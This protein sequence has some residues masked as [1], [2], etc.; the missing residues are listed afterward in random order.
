MNPIEGV[1]AIGAAQSDARPAGAMKPWT[2]A[3]RPAAGEP[4]AP[5]RPVAAGTSEGQVR[6]GTIGSDGRFEKLILAVQALHFGFAEDAPTAR[7]DEMRAAAEELFQIDGVPAP[8]E[9]AAG[10]AIGIDAPLP[11]ATPGAT[12]G[13]PP[14]GALPAATAPPKRAASLGWPAPAETARQPSAAPVPTAAAPAA[15][16]S[17]G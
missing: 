12:P 3:R 13:T 5:E 2:L 1:S 7:T 16:D 11:E 8:V 14:P 17:A 9:P 10:P 4:A 15:G 6:A